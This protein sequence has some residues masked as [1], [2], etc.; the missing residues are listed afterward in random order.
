MSLKHIQQSSIPFVFGKDLDVP[1]AD[2]YINGDLDI[3]GL[4]NGTSSQ[5]QNTNNTWTGT[6]EYSV[7]RPTSSLSSVGAQDGVNQTFLDTTITNEGII[8]QGSNWT[9]TNDFSA[10]GVNYIVDATGAYVYIPPVANTDA[11]QGKYVADSWNAKNASYLTSNNT[12]TGTN[13][14]SVLPLVIEPVSNTDVVSKNYCD[15]TISSITQGRATSVISQITTPPATPVDWGATALAV[16]LQIIG[17]GGG[18]TSSVG[19]CTCSSAGV[20]GGSGSQASLVIL[21]NSITGGGTNHFGLFEVSVGYGGK[22]GTGCGTESGSGSG[23]STNLFVTPTG[24]SGFNPARVNTLRA[25][26]GN[27][28]ANLSCGTAGTV[29]GGTYSAILPA[30]IAP[31]ASSNGRSGTQCAGAIPQYYGINTIGWGAR[32]SSCTSGI[33]GNNGGFCLTSFAP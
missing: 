17:A 21:T 13:T 1:I 25:N 26:G 14:F 11:V 31:F 22:A 6:N 16:Q 33:L 18:S 24:G 29:S 12:W 8:N 32:A 23:G 28:N 30:V 19:S 4:I 20:S 10:G 7:Y 9:G 15:T 3:Q 5:G 27:G 2:T